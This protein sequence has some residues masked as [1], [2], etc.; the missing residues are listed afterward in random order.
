MAIGGPVL[1]D[2][3]GAVWRV[4][5]DGGHG[6]HYFFFSS[7]RRHTSC[8]RDWSSD[9]CSSDLNTGTVT[10]GSAGWAGCGRIAVCVSSPSLPDHDPG[11]RLAAPAGP[12][13]GV[14]ERGNYRALSRGHGA[15]P[16]GRPAQAGLGR[17]GRPGGAGPAA[18]RR[19]ARPPARHTGHAADVAPPPDHP[20]VDDPN[21]PGRP[22][23]SQEIR[24]WYCGLRARTRPGIPQGARRAGPARS[25]HQRCDRQAD[26]ASPA[27]QTSPAERGHLLAGVPAH[28]SARTAGLRF[29]P[30]GH[31]LPPTPVCAVRDG[32]GDPARAYPRRERPPGRWYMLTA[33]PRITL[34]FT[35]TGCSWLNL[36]SGVLLLGHP[37]PGH[38]PRLLRLS[39]RARSGHRRVHRPLERSPQ[40]VWLDQGADEILAGIKRAKTKAN[41]LTKH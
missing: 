28:P 33:N 36:V 39:Q 11:L 16:A 30:C 26:L 38:P 34:H 14:Q 25:P 27:A 17:P 2:D 41:V 37:P 6:R 32:G 20:Q 22:R 9:V 3:R 1:D 29:L 15:A 18:T 12:Q 13:P 40:A 24:A 5:I 23:I 21:R 19:A 31:D 10:C 4:G 7:R 8:Y 35:P